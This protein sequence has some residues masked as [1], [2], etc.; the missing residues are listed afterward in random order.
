MT[1]NTSDEFRGDIVKNEVE[2]NLE[3][4]VKVMNENIELKGQLLNIEKNLE[5]NPWQKWIHFARMVDSWRLWSRA[6]I[7]VYMV[8]L[9]Y[10]TIWFMGLEAPSIEQSG[11]I[12]VIVGAGAAW[13]GLYVKS[14]PDNSD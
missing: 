11:L 2:M 12:S 1:S 4:F 5:I 13:F 3:K 7:T 10:T 6:F 14:G 9:Y 8:L